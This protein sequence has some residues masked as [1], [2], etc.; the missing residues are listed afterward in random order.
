MPRKKEDILVEYKNVSKN[1]TMYFEIFGDETERVMVKLNPG[2]IAFFNAK[3]IRRYKNDVRFLEG[4]IVP[5]NSEQDYSNTNTLENIMSDIRIE[6]FIKN[7]NDIELLEKQ[8]ENITNT[9]TVERLLNKA[10]EVS[11]L[12]TY[13]YVLLLE[14]KLKE[15]YKE[16]DKQYYGNTE[17]K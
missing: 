1:E 14:N 7:V 13:A 10:K 17:T 5:L 2:D 4:R 12:K 16:R 6:Y 3:D 11:N 15:L 8:L 9:N